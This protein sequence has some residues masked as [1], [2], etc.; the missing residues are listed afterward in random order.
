MQKL[1]AR[2]GGGEI[3]EQLLMAQIENMGQMDQKMLQLHDKIKP[4]S[5][6]LRAG[7]LQFKER[8]GMGSFGEVYRG[9]L[10]GSTPV[11]IKVLKEHH[12]WDSLSTE[13]NHGSELPPGVQDFFQEI[14]LWSELKHPNVVSFLGACVDGEMVCV[15]S[16]FMERGH[17]D[18]FFGKR[19]LSWEQKISIARDVA[20]A[21]AD[22]HSRIPPVLHRDLKSQN[23]LL[24]S[25]L[26]AKVTD[27]G[28]SKTMQ[29]TN[30]TASV[31]GTPHWMAPEVIRGE[32]YSTP[33]DVYSFGIVLWQLLT[34]L[35]SPFS[36]Q[37]PMRVQGQVLKGFRPEIPTLESAQALLASSS[38]PMHQFEHYVELMQQCWDPNPTHRP[39]FVEC[40]QVLESLGGLE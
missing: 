3:R 38:I 27:F 21:M 16:E 23:I 30:S 8:I 35:S 10:R 36:G 12:L 33:S 14:S 25:K 19:L 39:S 4:F 37:D 34:E 17:L 29:D 6:V 32:A 28:L 24:D 2:D 11:A 9:L 31:V 13:S 7:E 22:L 20:R 40:L 26:T 5:W 15:V 1:G 18:R